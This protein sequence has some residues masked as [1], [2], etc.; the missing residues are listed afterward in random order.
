MAQIFLVKSSSHMGLAYF[1]LHTQAKSSSS[2]SS[3]PAVHSNDVI[4]IHRSVCQARSAYSR[5]NSFLSLSLHQYPSAS[6]SALRFPCFFHFILQQLSVSSPHALFSPVNPVLCL[7]TLFHPQFLC[8]F[9]PLAFGGL[10]TVSVFQA[11]T[12]LLLMFSLRQS[13]SL[14]SAINNWKFCMVFLML[15]I[16]L[17]LCPCLWGYLIICLSCYFSLVRPEALYLPLNGIT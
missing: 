10:Q 15:F 4:H 5:L 3:S 11:L 17:A 2:S 6:P 14:V 8:H 7:L 13:S 9:Y 16:N 1:F 12:A